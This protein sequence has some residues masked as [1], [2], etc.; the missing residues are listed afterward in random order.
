[1]TPSKKKLLKP[2]EVS[3]DPSI[4]LDTPIVDLPNDENKLLD[5]DD[6]VGTSTI[7]DLSPPSEDEEEEVKSHD[8]W[9]YAIDTY[10]NFLHFTLKEKV[11]E[12]GSNTKIW[13]LWKSFSY[14]MK[15][16]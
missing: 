12:N 9:E 7:T 14:G 8:V 4:K 11:S 15:T 6:D 2:N 13:R 3:L 10:L 1:M 16:K 5:E